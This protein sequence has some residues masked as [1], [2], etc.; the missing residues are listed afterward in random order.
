MHPLLRERWAAAV[1]QQG[2]QIQITERILTWYMV[3]MIN[4]CGGSRS[5]MQTP[6]TERPSPPEESRA[7]VLTIA[8][9]N[10][11]RLKDIVIAAEKI[12]H[13]STDRTR[14]RVSFSFTRCS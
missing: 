9:P 4:E 3:L 13:F 7:A 1:Q 6:H 2:G 10:D 5:D 14:D 8:P 12:F 11:Q